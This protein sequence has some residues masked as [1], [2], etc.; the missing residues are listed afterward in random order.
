MFLKKDTAQLKKT[1]SEYQYLSDLAEKALNGDIE[2]FKTW[3]SHI[4]GSEATSQLWRNLKLEVENGHW[5][6]A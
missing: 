3:F 1:A 4:V 2:A 5:K 6:I